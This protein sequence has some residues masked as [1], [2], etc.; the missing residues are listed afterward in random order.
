MSTTANDR[1]S[2]WLDAGD[3]LDDLCASAENML[4]Q[5]GPQM[6]PGDQQSRRRVVTEARA[7]IDDFYRSED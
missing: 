3:A 1:I 4:L 2:R 7:V 5:F 6:S